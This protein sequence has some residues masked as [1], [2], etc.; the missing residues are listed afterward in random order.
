MT[1]DQ[2]PHILIVEDSD[3]QAMKLELLFEDAGWTS[4]R[5]ASAEAALEMLKDAL[6]DVIV[7]DYYLPGM[8]GD[9]FCR[10]VRMRSMTLHLPILML[11][12]ADSESTQVKLLDSGADDFLPKSEDPDV[13]IWRIQALL[14]KRE[15]QGKILPLRN[16]EQARILAIDDSPTYLTFLEEE[17]RQEGYFVATASSGQAG[18][19]QLQQ[20][21]FDCVLVDLVMPEIDGIEICR[22]LSERS[23]EHNSS[24][25]ILMLTAHDNATELSRALGAGAD[26]FVGKSSDISVLKGRVRALLRRKLFQ[27][28]NQRLLKEIIHSKEQEAQHALQAQLQA[29]ARAAMATELATALH[30]LQASK[31]ELEQLAYISAHDLQEPLR[32]LTNYSELLLRRTGPGLDGLGNQC[33]RFILDNTARMKRQVS[34]LLSYLSVSAA[35]PEFRELEVQLLLEKVR[36]RL[37]AHL[38]DTRAELIYQTP[39]PRLVAS[40]HHLEQLFW[41]LLHNAVLFRDESR[42]PRIEMGCREQDDSWEFWIKDNGIGIESRYFSQIFDIFQHLHDQAVYSTSGMGLAIC[43]RVVD[44]HGGRIWV[45]SDLGQGSRFAFTLAK[46]PAAEAELV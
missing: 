23:R 42:S 1:Q 5:A 26:D 19:A 34:S 39:W 44:L 24:L 14:R 18:L 15:R 25:L 16:F 29:E 11:T 37:A 41:H 7:V 32:H 4:S 38:S 27:D 10:Q 20:R 22:R 28:E 40:A 21:D 17:L 8:H 12:S 31:Q 6:P 46:R 2:P 35:E 33:L 9:A 3:T 43:R 13:L 36:S 45:E 30:R